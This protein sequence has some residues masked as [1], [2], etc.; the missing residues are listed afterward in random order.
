MLCIAARI[1]LSYAGFEVAGERTRTAG[2]LSV[3]RPYLGASLPASSLTRTSGLHL[4]QQYPGQHPG[5][6]HGCP[7]GGC[8]VHLEHGPAA[9]VLVEPAIRRN[10]FGRRLVEVAGRRLL[11]LLAQETALDGP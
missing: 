4:A 8:V 11:R 1:Q 7:D 9:G 10:P 5:A 2:L 3:S 6:E